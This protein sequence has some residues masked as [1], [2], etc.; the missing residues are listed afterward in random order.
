MGCSTGRQ[1]GS[2]AGGIDLNERKP[3]FIAIPLFKNKHLSD[4]AIKN[5]LLDFHP[6]LIHFWIYN[7]DT[8]NSF[9]TPLALVGQHEMERG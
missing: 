9:I 8:I 5:S 7:F 3:I 1:K 4:K 6:Y 2:W